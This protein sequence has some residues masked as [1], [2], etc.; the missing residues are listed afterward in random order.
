MVGVFRPRRGVCE[1]LKTLAYE[2]VN[3][4]ASSCLRP[5]G[6]RL[7]AVD[8][9]KTGS[10]PSDGPSRCEPFVLTL[11]ACSSGSMGRAAPW[12]SS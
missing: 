6:P 1:G 12:P 3:A 4:L 2:H 9:Q 5:K 10:G 7:P 11:T 8:A